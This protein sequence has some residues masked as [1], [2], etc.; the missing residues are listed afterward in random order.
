MVDNFY[1]QILFLLSLTLVLFLPGR[2]L[3]LAIF[4][5]S[6]FFSELE[7]FIISFGLSLVSIDFIFFAYSKL[8]LR[9]TALSAFLGIS[10]LILASLLVYKFRKFKNIKKEATN[11]LFSF[12]RKQISLILL[13]IFAIFLIKT[14]Y[15]YGAVLPTATDMGHHMYWAKEM[16]ET[17]KLPTYDGMPDFIIGEH[18]VFGVLALFSGAS[19]LGAFPV[20]VLY[21]FNL[22]AILAVFILVLRIFGNQKIAILSLF[23]LGVLYAVSSP[24]AK[25][26]SGGVVGNTLG[27]FLLPL[28][29]YFYFLAFEFLS[30]KEV[31]EELFSKTF[32]SLAVFLTFGLFYTHHLTSFIFLFIVPLA[33]LIY[34]VA[35]FNDV[36]NIGKK[37]YKTIL[38]PQVLAVFVLGLL[39]FFFVFTPNYIKGNAV[40]TAVGAPSKSTRVGL[41]LAN[42]ESTVGGMRLGMGFVGVLF[43]LLSYRRKNFG[44][45]I[46]LGWAVMLFIMSTRPDFLLIDLPSSRIGNYI[47]Y[48]IAILAAFSFYFV[49]SLS[50][51]E[52]LFFQNLKK[53]IL[54]EFLLKSGFAVL[55][56][57]LL[58]FGISDSVASF[59]IPADYSALFETFEAS[60]YLASNSTEKDMILKDHNYLT[61]DT[62]MKLFFMRGYRYPLS[63][64]YFKRYEDETNPRE[65]CTLQMISSPASKEAENCFRETGT[66]FVVVNP[67]YDGA[68]FE[69]NQEWNHVYDSSGVSVYYKK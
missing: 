42:L 63:R 56:S 17:G 34:L 64:S 38:S 14:S 18:I 62:W 25:F 65:M 30:R 3:L 33:V 20:I 61:G 55:F 32:L 31:R 41:S 50:K 16:V 2:F 39:F 58:F 19:F 11:P 8:N 47:T 37:I 24:Q 13:L 48:P 49:F 22:L 51:E 45:A 68:Q 43:L 53:I 28:A 40:E 29:F 35:N 52:R 9:I 10:F 46:V 6:R 27:N 26:V 60:K 66:N 1:T 15:L 54:P 7:K 23:F 12:S 57:G 36:Q 59:R 44:Y 69:K 5:R 21:L 67:L 4:G